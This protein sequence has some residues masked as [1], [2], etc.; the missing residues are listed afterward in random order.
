[1]WSGSDAIC[2]ESYVDVKPFCWFSG[3]AVGFVSTSTYPDELG[4]VEAAHLKQVF[5]DELFVFPAEWQA[6]IA[7]QERRAVRGESAGAG[8]FHL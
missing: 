6:S 8:H 2:W 5:Q 7:E 3:R 1:V 4:V